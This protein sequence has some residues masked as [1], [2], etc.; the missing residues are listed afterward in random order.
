MRSSGGTGLTASRF[1]CAAV[2]DELRWDAVPL[3]TD[4][5]LELEFHAPPEAIEIEHDREKIQAIAYHLLNNAIKFTAAGHV[6]VTLATAND[7]ISL[8]VAD[9]GVGVPME[10]RPLMFEDFRQVDGSSTRRFDGLGL[11]LG[12]V[13]RFTA[14]L[15]GTIALQSVPG[16]GTTV[17]VDIPPF[18]CHER[19]ANG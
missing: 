3:N 11:G 2:L 14:L 6:V 1:T 17:R 18:D 16:I 15:G 13:K 4:K 19:S 12:I 9:T 7:G 10:A 8:T 5:G